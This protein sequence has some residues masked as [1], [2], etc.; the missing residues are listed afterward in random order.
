VIAA[1][2]FVARDRGGGYPKSNTGTDSITLYIQSLL[3]RLEESMSRLLAS[4]LVW[5][6]AALVLAGIGCGSGD[7][8][9][10]TSTEGAGGAGG[11]GGSTT[12]SMSAGSGTGGM[13]AGTTGTG[14]MGTGGSAGAGGTG[15]GPPVGQPPEVQINHPGDME[16]RPANM[17]IPFVAGANDPEDGDLSGALIWTSNLSGQFG[18]GAMFNAPLTAG[19]HTITATV[20]D[21]DSNTAADSLILYI[22]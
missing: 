18:T 16:M 3:L 12:G 11:A 8:T 13:G 19:T 4:S 6:A 21:S 7:G 2:A 20:T 22:Q 15:G 10:F 14:G 9:A 17:P 5:I 1:S